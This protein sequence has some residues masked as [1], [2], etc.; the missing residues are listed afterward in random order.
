MA[1]DG[2]PRSEQ[3]RGPAITCGPRPGPKPG[4]RS[5]FQ[6]RQRA[7]SREAILAAAN[8]LLNATAF[9]DIAIE[10]ILAR[11]P[12]SRATFYRHFRSKYELA[13]ALYEQVF[14]SSMP[15]WD[16]LAQASLD[17]ARATS[18]VERMID[19][20]RTAGRASVLILQ[21]GVTD[22][23]F[24][25]RLRDDRH[26]LVDHLGGALP[27]FAR[28]AGSSPDACK[29]RAEADLLLMLLDRVCVEIAVH[30]SLPNQA[31]YVALI[32]GQLVAFLEGRTTIDNTDCIA[33]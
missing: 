7:T 13:L 10:D 20:Y 1:D 31:E 29:A 30:G 21:L 2:P 8:D 16:S 12:C 14:A 19:N 32:A 3:S 18:W 22:A 15:L 26:G 33:E 23:R 27:A 6:E 28:A 17:P 9:D 25:Q 5:S 4:A 11:A 24:H